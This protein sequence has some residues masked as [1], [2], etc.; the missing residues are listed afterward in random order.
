MELGEETL[1]ESS[2]RR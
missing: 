2:L 1:V